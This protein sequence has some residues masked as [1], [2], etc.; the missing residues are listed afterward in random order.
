M[1]SLNNLS[2]KKMVIDYVV[3]ILFSTAFTMIYFW[4]DLTAY[5]HFE[6]QYFSDYY[7]CMTMAQFIGFLWA[8]DRH[9]ENRFGHMVGIGIVTAV[10]P[11]VT[12]I[13]IEFHMRYFIYA[14]ASIFMPLYLAYAVRE[15]VA[16]CH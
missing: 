4:P 6:D 13:M 5:L 8:Y 16:D 2:V 3:I 7:I 9:P 14:M 15:S 12:N 10:L 11:V 1:T